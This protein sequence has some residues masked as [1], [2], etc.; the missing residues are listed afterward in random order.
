M[1]TVLAWGGLFVFVSVLWL[2]QRFSPDPLIEAD[3]AAAR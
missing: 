2:Y 1:K 3:H